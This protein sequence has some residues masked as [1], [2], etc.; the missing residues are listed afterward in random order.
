MRYNIPKTFK[1]EFC[2]LLLLPEIQEYAGGD[3]ICRAEDRR[4]NNS[5]KKPAAFLLTPQA[6]TE[7]QTEKAPYVSHFIVSLNC[8]LIINA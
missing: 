7:F 3:C 5:T 6:Q 8:S 2:F 4:A 1:S